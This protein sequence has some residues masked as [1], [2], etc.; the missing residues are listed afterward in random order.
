[1]ALAT[2]KNSLELIFEL[3]G[4]TL[5]SRAERIIVLFASPGY[6]MPRDNRRRFIF[7]GD[8]VRRVRTRTNPLATNRV[9]QV[10]A[11]EREFSLRTKNHIIE[12]D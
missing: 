7:E 11:V 2:V 5:P 4:I 3:N 8:A 10:C 6:L 9:L 1:M 12:V